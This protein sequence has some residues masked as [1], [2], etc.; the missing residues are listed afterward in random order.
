NNKSLMIACASNAADIISLSNE[1]YA[2]ELIKSDKTTG[3]DLAHD[4]VAREEHRTRTF[5]A[6]SA[7]ETALTTAFSSARWVYNGVVYDKET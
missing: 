7:L 4:K 1:K 5:N 2:L 3:A 6:Q